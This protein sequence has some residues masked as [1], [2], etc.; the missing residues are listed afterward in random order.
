MREK[1]IQKMLPSEDHKAAAVV[2][3]PSAIK[4]YTQL[5]AYDEEATKRKKRKYDREYFCH[6]TI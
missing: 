1:S 6:L 3:V 4:K 2:D 5:C